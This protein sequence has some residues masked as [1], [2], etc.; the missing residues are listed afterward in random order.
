MYELLAI[1]KRA[2]RSFLKGI[3]GIFEISAF[4]IIVDEQR[5]VLLCHRTDVDLWNLPGGGVEKGETPRQAV[6]REVKEET[7]FDAEVRWLAGIYMNPGRRKV[8]FTFVCKVVG[9]K[10][11]TS[12]ESDA[13]KYFAFERIP[14]YTYPHHIA[15]VRD[16]LNRPDII[17]LKLE[18][19]PSA[20]KLLKKGKL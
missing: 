3:R 15:R 5:Q 9:G 6:M 12:D 17:H 16:A 20:K 4:G 19:G 1:L 7:G 18:H 10:K 11:T 14:R 8:S 2:F 13:V